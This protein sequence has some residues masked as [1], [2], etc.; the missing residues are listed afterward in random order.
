MHQEHQLDT[1]LLEQHD[2]AE[3]NEEKK[4]MPVFGTGTLVDPALNISNT[5]FECVRDYFRL[6]S[7]ASSMKT[8]F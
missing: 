5:T 6:F 4:G 3:T 7:T 2:S 1:T 8:Y